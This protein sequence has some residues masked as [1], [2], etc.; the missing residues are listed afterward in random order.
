MRRR[1]QSMTEYVVLIAVF[2]AGLIIASGY[3]KR[4]ISGKLKTSAD[5]ISEEQFGATYNG[6]SWSQMSSNEIA[7]TN[8]A[9]TNSYW[10]ESK[11]TGTGLG[12]ENEVGLTYK[13]GQ[14]SKSDWKINYNLKG[15]DSDIWEE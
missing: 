6:M 13:G 7:G 5:S 3:V 4:A 11:L 2:V 1:A 8:D 12:L 14:V 9:I 10:S 15:G